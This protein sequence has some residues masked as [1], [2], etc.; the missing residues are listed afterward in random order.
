[1][2]FHGL[3]VIEGNKRGKL[4]G[5]HYFLGG[6]RSCDCYWVGPSGGKWASSTMKH[7]DSYFLAMAEALEMVVMVEVERIATGVPISV[8]SQPIKFAK[9]CKSKTTQKG[10]KESKNIEQK[11]KK[12]PRKRWD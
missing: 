2:G 3:V 4:K 6:L 1:M 12:Y 7:S 10:N 8:S 11:Q 9:Q 5:V